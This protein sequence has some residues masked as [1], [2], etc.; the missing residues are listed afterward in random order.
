MT[1]TRMTAVL[2]SLLLCAFASVAAADDAPDY[3]ETPRGE[4]PTELTWNLTDVYAD[5]DLWRSDLESLKT[6]LPELAKREAAWTE[7]AADAY[8]YLSYIDEIEQKYLLLSQYA[9]LMG[10]GDITDPLYTSMAG[11]ASA[12]AV[13]FSQIVGGMDEQ[14]V[15][16]GEERF[17]AFLKKEPKLGDYEFGVRDVLRRSAH[18]LTAEQQKIADMTGL[19][20]EAPYT[21]FNMLN[22][23]EI[24]NPEITLADG[25]V[26]KL[27]RAAYYRLAESKV[28]DDRILAAQ[29]YWENQEGFANSLAATLDAGCKQHLFEARIRDYDSCLQ[30]ALFRENIE[31]AV[32]FNTIEQVRSRADVLQR[33]LV[34]KKKMMGLDALRLEDTAVNA[35]AAVERKYTWEQARDIVMAAFQ[36][37]GPEYCGVLKKAFDERWV[38]IYPNKDKQSGAFSSMVYGVHP[39]I[40][41]NY[42]GQYNEVGTIAHELGH[43]VQS[44]L[45]A[46]NQPYSLHDF[47][48]YISEV[49]STFNEHMINFH[50]L[51]TDDDPLFR[52]YLL[53]EYMKRARTLIYFSTMMSE[54]EVSMHELVE[55]DGTVT[56]DFMSEAMLGLM[57]HYYGHD[58]DICEVPEYAGAMWSVYP[59]LF[60]NYYLLSYCN[61][62]IASMAASEMV[63][64]SDDYRDDYLKYLKAGG[65]EY[66]L[67]LLRIAKIDLATDRPFDLAFARLGKLL[68]EMEVLVG[69]LQAD[70]RL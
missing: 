19:F 25:A 45:S 28:R 50:L 42:Q 61:G 37:L 16:L 40:K 7:S 52:L 1:T 54:L 43:A 21:I 12:V 44:Y 38:D 67:D 13:E 56:G 34:L 20:T 60:M 64:E 18:M 46:A 49:A 3:S 65:S 27:N 6:M 30:A 5:D 58:A 8:A 9:G 70:G 35:V 41:M 2:L 66:S 17:E 36:P 32:Y 48:T 22:D 47:P 24:P 59:H 31:P 68:D 63:L 4:I 10:V 53:D 39:Y 11:E 29:T 14:I 62:F 15:A 26:V 51:E 33:Y 69:E 57:R 55:N 23:S